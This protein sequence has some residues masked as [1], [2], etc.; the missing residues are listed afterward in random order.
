MEFNRIVAAALL[1][2]LSLSICAVSQTQRL[3]GI[4]HDSNG[5]LV[6]GARVELNTGN[7]TQT[8]TTDSNGKF[9]FAAVTA[10]SGTISV[11]S[12]YTQGLRRPWSGEGVLELVLHVGAP[13]FCCETCICIDKPQI[14]VVT[15]SK[16]NVALEDSPADVVAL[17]SDHLA[18]T[19]ALTL[20]DVLREV[21][22]FTLFR[23]SSSRTANPGTQGVSMR[24]V[25]ASGA[26]RALVLVDDIPLNDPF[27]GWVYWDR[28]VRDSISEVEV[29]RGGA[30][31]SL[32]GSTA[33]G[34]VIQF[35]TREPERTTISAEGSWGSEKRRRDLCTRA[36]SWGRGKFPCIGFVPDEWVHSCA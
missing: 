18:S 24:G 32:Y 3:E 25:G 20:D 31:A 29:V 11:T 35:R 12:N 34:G 19:A 9:L 21:P 16:T 22:G 33:M 15:A 5:K 2:V 10:G 26:S 13:G 17:D 4:V 8:T 36:Q 30:D 6:V 23:R 14:V 1:S 7:A 27:G 28:V